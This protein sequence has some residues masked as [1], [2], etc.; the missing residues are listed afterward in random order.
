[1]MLWKQKNRKIDLI[2]NLPNVDYF[3]IPKETPAYRNKCINTEISR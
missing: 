3:R 1:M 2:L